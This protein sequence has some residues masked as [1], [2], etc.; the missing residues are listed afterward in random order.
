LE[1]RDTLGCLWFAGVI[2]VIS[3]WGWLTSVGVQQGIAA[4][5]ALATVAG[6]FVLFYFAARGARPLS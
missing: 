2:A 1:W 3:F 4:L 6:L 5:I